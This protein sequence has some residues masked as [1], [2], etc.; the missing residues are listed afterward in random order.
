MAG[1]I[2][3][4]SVIVAGINGEGELELIDKDWRADCWGELSMHSGLDAFISEL[5]EV[6]A[7]AFGGFG[8]GLLLPEAVPLEDTKPPDATGPSSTVRGV[9]WRCIQFSSFLVFPI[10]SCLLNEFFATSG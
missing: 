1:L 7:P 6:E 5:M 3:S 2:A 9:L 8:F 4:G 10:L